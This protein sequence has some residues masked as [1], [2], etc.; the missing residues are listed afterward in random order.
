MPAGRPTKYNQDMHDLAEHYIDHHKEDYGDEMP[1]AE[2]MSLVL[3]VHKS[4]LYEWA[5]DEEKNF[6]D[7][8]ARCQAKQHQVLF[9]K[10]LT[11]DFNATIVKLALSNHGYSDKTENTMQ[12]PGGGPIQT[13]NKWIVEVVSSDDSD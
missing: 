13:D 9:N 12:G 6:S 7:T 8:L 10:G 2:G 5:Q 4:T 1:S 11:N 3:N